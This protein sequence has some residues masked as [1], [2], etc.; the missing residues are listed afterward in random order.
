MQRVV[1]ELLYLA[2][3]CHIV[4]KDGKEIKLVAPKPP[5]P[6]GSGKLALLSAHP[7]MATI[8]ASAPTATSVDAPVMAAQAMPMPFSLC[9]A[10]GLDVC[11]ASTNDDD[12]T[13]ALVAA[14]A[15]PSSAAACN[16]D[17]SEGTAAAKSISMLSHKD[18]LAVSAALQGD[19]K[20]TGHAAAAVASPR[21]AV[22]VC[23][24]PLRD[25]VP[26]L[27]FV[28]ESDCAQAG[29]L[30][31]AKLLAERERLA[32]QV[33]LEGGDD[34]SG[35]EHASAARLIADID[36]SIAAYRQAVQEVLSPE[37]MADVRLAVGAII[38]VYIRWRVRVELGFTCSVGVASNKALAKLATGRNKPAQQTI[39]P[40][41]SVP[42]LMQVLPIGKLRSLGGKKGALLKEATMKAMA[43]SLAAG[44][45]LAS[46]AS[47]AVLLADP[48]PLQSRGEYSYGGIVAPAALHFAGRKPAVA[49][50]AAASSGPSSDG[51]SLYAAGARIVVMPNSKGKVA[52]LAPSDGYHS[53]GGNLADVL[54]QL[55]ARS[56]PAWG[57]AAAGAESD[58]E[59]D[60][61]ASLSDGEDD[62]SVVLGTLNRTGGAA[63]LLPSGPCAVLVATDDSGGPVITAG[64]VLRFLSQQQLRLVFPDVATSKA[65]YP[66][67]ERVFRLLHGIC[68][69]GLSPATLLVKSIGSS[70]AVQGNVHAWAPTNVDALLSFIVWPV[71][72]DIAQRLLEEACAYGRSATKLEVS[73]TWRRSSSASS[74]G[75]GEKKSASAPFPHP[76]APADSKVRRQPASEAVRLAE[77]MCLE[78]AR[79]IG[80]LLPAGSIISNL[81]MKATDFVHSAGLQQSRVQDFFSLAASAASGS[82]AAA[83]AGLPLA[84]G[85]VHAAAPRPSSRRGH[86]PTV[87]D[88]VIAGSALSQIRPTA[89]VIDD[90]DVPAVEDSQGAIIIADG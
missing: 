66:P 21:G 59:E 75:W 77:A 23:V 44:G 34:C 36:A 81:S 30:P 28:S 51:S 53:G 33:R 57:A 56:S 64:H 79:L 46:A 88:A 24:D 72:A 63:S 62:G 17:D 26:P 15:A 68:D 83:S 10:P 31:M 9:A 38:G 12:V 29:I 4:G 3:V 8:P 43:A 27:P 7:V 47:A 74:A 18:F 73:V 54:R 55:G 80:G 35:A 71:C 41:A 58:D 70:K 90:D 76:V 1:D 37:R 50:A 82:T 13:P 32:K 20:A 19:D 49:F 61:L 86:P 65:D 11:S 67:S 25:V 22:G 2:G 40:A 89:I 85:S 87:L 60:D 84:A 69:D 14:A 48:P 52:S 42:G 5:E 45:R 39:V 78:A 6:A 16:D